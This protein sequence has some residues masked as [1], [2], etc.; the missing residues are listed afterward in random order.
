MGPSEQCRCQVF[1][2]SIPSYNSISANI[3]KVPERARRVDCWQEANEQ[4]PLY[5]QH[6]DNNEE[7]G[8]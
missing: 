5:P 1:I 3:M 7:A 2:L 4:Q 8:S 6:E